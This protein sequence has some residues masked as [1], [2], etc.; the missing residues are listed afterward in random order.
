MALGTVER[1]IVGTNALMIVL[2]F[3]Q[4][5]FR[6]AVVNSKQCDKNVNEWFLVNVCVLSLLA[7]KIVLMI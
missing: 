3:I 1:Y 5:P 7:F 2:L 6:D 4:M